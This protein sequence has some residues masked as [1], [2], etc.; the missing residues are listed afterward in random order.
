[1][2]PV[3]DEE[4]GSPTS[5]DEIARLAAEADVVLS[6]EGAREDGSV[7]SS[8]KG[9]ADV[10]VALTGRAAHP[11]VDAERGA[12]AVVAAAL[13][14]ADLHRITRRH[15]GVS[16]QRRQDLRRRA[17]QR[18]RR[19][20]HRGTRGARRTPAGTRRGDP[21]AS[22]TS[23]T[24]PTCRASRRLDAVSLTRARRCGRDP[25]QDVVLDEARAVAHALG[26][27]V[28]DAATGA[29][30]DANYAAAAGVPTLDGLGPVGGDDHSVD[31]W[32]DLD[33]VVPRIALLACLI[34]RLPAAR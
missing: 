6:L 2:L 13:L 29:P 26:F 27:A 3:P 16:G 23:S 8:R 1:M 9:I 12:N 11:G 7:V 18:R 22:A 20:G 33:S 17:G 28:G 19:L 25:A 21:P 31:E 32:L 34:T 4:I 5:R 10:A 30:A 15:A 24:R 14:I